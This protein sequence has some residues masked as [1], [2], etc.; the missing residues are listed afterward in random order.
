[1][2]AHP[3]TLG[4]WA[5]G[6]TPIAQTVFF[7]GT[8]TPAAAPFS[9]TLSSVT[10]VIPTVPGGPNASVTAF[11]ITLGSTMKVKKTV[12]GKKKTVTI[13]SVTL[14][15]KCTGV[16]HWSASDA[17]TDGTTNMTTATTPCPPK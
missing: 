3:L 1:M 6:T 11:S 10:P 7:N 4:F 9:Q 17:Y 13:S 14:P 16:M 12:H 15:K 2:S 8:L 5:N